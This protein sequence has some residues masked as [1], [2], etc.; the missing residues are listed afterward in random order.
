MRLRLRLT[1]RAVKSA[2]SPPCCEAGSHGRNA[3]ALC[4]ARFA[5]RRRVLPPA[6]CTAL[7]TALHAGECQSARVLP[8]RVRRGV[9]CSPTAVSQPRGRSR[10]AALAGTG[11]RREQNQA[12]AETAACLRLPAR[13]AGVSERAAN[14]PGPASNALDAWTLCPS[15][16]LP[17]SSQVAARAVGHPV[18]VCTRAVAIRTALLAARR[19]VG[20]QRRVPGARDRPAC[21][22]G[23]L[24][25]PA[26]QRTRP[27]EACGIFFA[28]APP[29]PEHRSASQRIASLT[30][31]ARHARHH[32]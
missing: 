9:S 7:R 16:S 29:R 6:R 26:R 11:H 32:C 18:A 17:A 31:D 20:A 14:P 8:C 27:R 12:E 21:P 24:L 1:L 15:R 25:P 13:A 23:R 5:A 10:C 30:T 22:P 2:A 3:D 19:A 4:A 28:P